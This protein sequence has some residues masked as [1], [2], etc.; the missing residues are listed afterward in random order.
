MP[1]P[2]FCHN[3]ECS[4]NTAPRRGWR[5]RYGHYRSAAHGLVQRYRC[6]SCGTTASSQT[7]SL[8]YCAKRRLPLRAIWLSLLGGAS[9]REVARRY[10]TTP[11]AVQYAVL[12]LGRQAMAAQLLLLAGLNPRR[13]VVFDGLRSFVTSQDYPCDLTTAVES[14]G[15]V[16]LSITH[17]VSR[18]G[19]KPRAGQRPRLAQKY[20]VWR[21]KRGAMKADISRLSHE[22]W[23]YLRPEQERAAV[24]DTDEQPLYR[25]VLAADQTAIHFRRFQRFAHVRT[26]STAPRTRANRLFPVNYVDRLLRHRV[27][28]HTRETIAFGRHATMQ[29]HR[30]WIFACDHNVNREHRVRAPARGVHAAQGVVEP[31]TTER[32]RRMLFHR[33]IFPRDCLVPETLRRVWC[34]EL[35]TPPHRWRRGQKGTSVRVPAYAIRQLWGGYQHTR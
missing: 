28:E 2:L 12:R 10:R 31:A 3:P 21:P 18:R 33:R 17:T 22:I 5:I 13:R 8:H 25:A 4:N 34:A 11:M 30:C 16:I 23:D 1:A 7:E 14:A 27:K 29:M 19:G 26:S 15:E 35:P 20:A 32:I 6:R 24:I 9:Q